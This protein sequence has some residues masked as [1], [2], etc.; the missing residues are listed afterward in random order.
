MTPALFLHHTPL[1]TV[2]DTIH[3]LA[4]ESAVGLFLIKIIL[5][6]LCQTLDFFTGKIHPACDVL[7]PVC[8]VV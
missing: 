4:F 3:L 7:V 6:I 2:A 8:F 1:S 5:K